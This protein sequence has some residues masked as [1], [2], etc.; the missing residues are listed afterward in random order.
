MVNDSPSLRKPSPDQPHAAQ[1][2]TDCPVTLHL[3]GGYCA[4]PA[5]V[6]TEIYLYTSNPVPKPAGY[7]PTE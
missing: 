2:F 4:F 7:Q 6:K 3:S 5:L 1:M